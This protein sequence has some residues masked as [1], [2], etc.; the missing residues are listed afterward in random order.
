MIHKEYT[1]T[2]VTMN[3]EGSSEELAILNNED[4]ISIDVPQ[5]VRSSV[6][7]N[8]LNT[9]NLHFSVFNAMGI[10]YAGQKRSYVVCLSILKA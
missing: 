7:L 2:I 4:N 3:H 1:L 5:S 9:F 10:S 8:R 6:T